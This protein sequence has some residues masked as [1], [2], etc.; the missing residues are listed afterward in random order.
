LP[1]DLP[2]ILTAARSR[3][4]FVVDDAAQCMGGSVAGRTSGTWGDVGIYSLDKGK[5]ITS[6]DGGV[7]VSNSDAVASA[8]AAQT[9]S[10]PRPG[11]SR[12]L[13]HVAKLL[14]YAAM[15]HPGR[16][17]IPNGLPFLH[18]GT[19][20]Y[21]T[22]YP[23]EQ[24]DPWLA[25]MGRRLF[26]ALPDINAQRVGNAAWYRKELPWSRLL[27]PVIPGP[28]TAPVY[29]RFPI[30]VDPGYRD[31]V[32][33]GLVASGIGATASYPS[34]ICD[35]PEVHDHV[36]N[37]PDAFPGGRAVAGRIVTLPTHPY[38]APRDR[39]SMVRVLNDIL[40]GPGVP[41]TGDGTDRARDSRAVGATAEGRETI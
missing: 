23:L 14:A 33:A 16:Y 9:R 29:L 28:R 39:E 11:T 7:I 37:L 1:N 2:A 12:S 6:I 38:V 10:L 32:V 20:V 13:T 36:R 17:W 24:Y 40:G 22:D 21:R 4:V 34:A 5:S 3:N 31:E 15:L 35:V 25:P 30:L 18:L 26:G 8:L 41:K 19:T 27:E